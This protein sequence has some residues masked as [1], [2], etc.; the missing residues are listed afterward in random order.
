MAQWDSFEDVQRYVMQDQDSSKS[1]DPRPSDRQHRSADGFLDPVLFINFILANIMKILAMTVALT[2]LFVSGFLFISFPYKAKAIILVDP[3]EIGITISENVVSNIDGNAAVL[4]SVVQLIQSD[5]FLSPLIKAL[6]VA[7]DPQFAE[8]SEFSK[9]GDDRHLVRQFKNQLNVNRVGATFVVEISFES[10]DSERAA[11]YAN[12]VARAFVQDEKN[13]RSAATAN[14]AESLSERLVDLR[15]IL[16]KSEQ[17]AADFRAE[18]NI[19]SIDGV[20]TLQQRELT[21]LS[22]QVAL[23][24]TNT[25]VARAIYSQLVNSGAIGFNTLGDQAEAEQLR[26]L[27]QQRTTISQNLIELNL[28]LGSRHPRISAEQS[29]LAA[30][31]QQIAQERQALISLGKQ[32]FDAAIDTQNALEKDLQNLRDRASSTE[33]FLVT[34]GELDREAD[35]NREIY[36]EFLSRFKSADEQKEFNSNEARL[37]SAAVPP[38]TTTQPSLKLVGGLAGILSFALSTIFFLSVA[39]FRGVRERAIPGPSEEAQAPQ[40]IKDLSVKNTFLPQNEHAAY[41]NVSSSPK[42]NLLSIELTPS[43]AEA[44]PTG[45]SHPTKSD[46]VVPPVWGD[47]SK[48]C[49]GLPHIPHSNLK[50]EF[51]LEQ[52][53]AHEL[54]RTPKLIDK[55]DQNSQGAPVLLVSSWLPR[56]GKTLIS[57]SLA[58]LASSRQLEP[59]LLK[60]PVNSQVEQ[61]RDE[62]VDKLQKAYSVLDPISEREAG[63]PL[64]LTSFS[65][66]QSIIRESRKNF[67][68]V[69]IDA[70]HVSN[71]QNFRQLSTASDKTLLIFDRPEES[72]IDIVANKTANAGF[73]NAEIILNNL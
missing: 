11:L 21:E 47:V 41:S 57:Q 8:A 56:E 26:T 24:K 50:N 3:R 35:A 48:S 36:E 54:E 73:K 72:K 29:K 53:L 22:K 39:V 71:E 59:I 2:V 20:N 31:D 61:E 42:L 38:L 13:F 58:T 7:D 9:Q 30:I 32:R 37:A 46:A 65:V 27:R 68:L 23:A 19:I 52:A 44:S 55:D 14:A 51:D 10:S 62:S 1:T 40:A 67:G 17:K 6:N 69:I 28:T 25:E 63:L 49:I 12:G 43:N 4:E 33:A 18:H 16:L 60:T 70:S 64:D 66:F 45:T 34:L 5:G 15:E